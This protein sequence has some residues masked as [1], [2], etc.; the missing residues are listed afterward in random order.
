M[1]LFSSRQESSK[2]E[3]PRFST[4][5]NDH[6]MGGAY[7]FTCALYVLCVP[8]FIFLSFRSASKYNDGSIFSLIMGNCAYEWIQFVLS[9][10]FILI[11]TVIRTSC[12]IVYTAIRWFSLVINCCR[13]L[14]FPLPIYHR[15]S[16]ADTI[17][18]FL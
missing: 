6:K 12:E 4:Q 15:F 8:L 16:Q 9:S 18:H 14:K 17:K 1:Q 10:V 3:S 2:C 13:F 5:R 7:P 11:T